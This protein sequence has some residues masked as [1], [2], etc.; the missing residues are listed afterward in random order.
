MAE[1]I[2]LMEA[3]FEYHTEIEGEQTVPKEELI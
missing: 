3:G 2:K 1:A